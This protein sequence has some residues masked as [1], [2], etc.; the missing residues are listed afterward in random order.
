MCNFH[1]D[2]TRAE[3]EALRERVT[4]AE[5]RAKRFHQA[6]TAIMVLTDRGSITAAEIQKIIADTEDPPANV[7]A[8][9][10]TQGTIWLTELGR[11]NYALAED[12]IP[13]FLGKNTVGKKVLLFDTIRDSTRFE[14]Y[15]ARLNFS[16]L[17]AI[18]LRGYTPFMRRE[19]LFDRI[20]KFEVG[21]C[22]YVL[23]D[24]IHD[25]FFDSDDQSGFDNFTDKLSERAVSLGFH[26]IIFSYS[27]PSKA[28]VTT[29]PIR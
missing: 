11:F 29:R 18:S 14:S 2:T 21:E 28:M 25:L 23:I 5:S 16:N 3:I 9:S 4:T 20:D 10:A 22:V 26:V 8:A 6:L 19:K 24:T 1:N 17:E 7:P 27:G 13:R 15:S 12:I